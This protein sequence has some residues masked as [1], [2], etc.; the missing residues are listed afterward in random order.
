MSGRAALAHLVRKVSVSLLN[1]T[2]DP[3]TANT[4]TI[5]V[6]VDLGAPNFD[7][8][9]EELALLAKTA[10]MKPVARVTCKRRA[11]DA[12]LFIG[13]GK[14]DEIKL[15]AAQLGAKEVLFDQS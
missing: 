8:E 2:A 11:P 1:L 15:L 7:G 3:A 13:S 14:A 5:L 9:L 10:G 12:A 6:G 4:P